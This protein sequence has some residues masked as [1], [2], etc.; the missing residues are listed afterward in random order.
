LWLARRYKGHE[1]YQ[2]V[3]LALADDYVD[4]PGTMTFAEAQG[5]AHAVTWATAQARRKAGGYT[6]ADALRDYI[7][8]QRANRATARDA[9]LRARAHILPHLGKVPVTELTTAMI[10]DWLNLIG[11]SGC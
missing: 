6:V 2:V 7:A 4:S 11:S 3:P 1:R 8:W 9:E 5:A 10:T